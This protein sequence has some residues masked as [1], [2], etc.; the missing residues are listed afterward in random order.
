VWHDVGGVQ[1]VKDKNWVPSDD[2]ERFREN[3]NAYENALQGGRHADPRRRLTTPDRAMHLHEATE[4][5]EEVVR[6]W[7][8]ER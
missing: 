6:R 8:R 7:L 1:A 5:R 2:L 3:A 4:V